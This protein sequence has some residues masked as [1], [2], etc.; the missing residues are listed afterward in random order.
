MFYNCFIGVHGQGAHGSPRP[1]WL[2][3]SAREGAVWLLLASTYGKRQDVLRLPQS[4]R[5]GQRHDACWARRLVG[6]DGLGAAHVDEVTQED[7]ESLPSWAALRPLQQR[8][9]LGSRSAGS[10]VPA[11]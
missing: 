10:G 4:T 9:L 1:G 7:W 2:L 3:A 6:A 5:P 11:P 8:R